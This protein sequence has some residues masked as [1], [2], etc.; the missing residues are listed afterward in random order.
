MIRTIVQCD[1]CGKQDELDN[2]LK[3]NDWVVVTISKAGTKD[4]CTPEH[5]TMDSP[6][7]MKY[8]ED[9]EPTLAEAFGALTKGVMTAIGGGAR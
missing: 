3:P 8:L 1:Y 5:M 9:R 4:Y 7:V 6:N 2:G